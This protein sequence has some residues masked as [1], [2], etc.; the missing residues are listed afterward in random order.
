[1][2]IHFNKRKQKTRRRGRGRGWRGD[3]EEEEKKE[4]EKQNATIQGFQTTHSPHCSVGQKCNV[5][6]TCWSLGVS[7]ALCFR[8]FRDKSFFSLLLETPCSL[9][10]GPSPPSSKCAHWLLVPIIPYS[11]W[12]KHTSHFVGFTLIPLH[13]GKASLRGDVGQGLRS[14]HLRR[15]L[16]FLP[17]MLC[18]YYIKTMA[19]S[20]AWWPV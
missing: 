3:E 18:I 17:Q 13:Y 15:L 12:H 16:V 6:D 1:M 19:W 8:S 11:H 9:L 7:R 4:K 14:G 2:W 20:Q 10:C 5:S